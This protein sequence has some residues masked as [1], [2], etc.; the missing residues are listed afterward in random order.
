M[1]TGGRNLPTTGFADRK[2]IRRF[3]ASTGLS[4]HGKTGSERRTVKVPRLTH[5]G[6]RASKHPASPANFPLA[7]RFEAVRDSRTQAN[8]A[9]M[10]S[11]AR[12]CFKNLRH[13][14]HKNLWF[15]EHRA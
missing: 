5:T 11:A 10:H 3:V 8:G 14:N 7:G 13:P 2:N 4:R 6:S 15:R 12:N 9:A 1:G